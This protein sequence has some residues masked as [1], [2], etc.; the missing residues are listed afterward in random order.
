MGNGLEKLKKLPRA[1]LAH[2]PTPIEH[3]P[4]LSVKIGVTPGYGQLNSPTRE[5]IRLGAHHEALLLDPVY[6]G[7]AFAGCLQRAQELDSQ[8]T[9]LFVH[10]GGTPGIFAYGA[11]LLEGQ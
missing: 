8:E 4:S 10:T 1:I 2:T 5:A 3:L 6:T 9:L 7:K 11:Q